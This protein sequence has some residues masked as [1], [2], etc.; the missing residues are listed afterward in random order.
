MTL[1]CHIYLGDEELVEEWRQE[2][3]SPNCAEDGWQCFAAVSEYD[4]LFVCVDDS[5]EHYGHIRHIV[6]NCFEDEVCMVG[7]FDK[8]FGVIEKFAH[9]WVE[10]CQNAQNCGTDLDEVECNFLEYCSQ[11]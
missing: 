10:K 9:H 4:Y 5:S 7:T 3:D 8:L 11:M 6:N 1:R 2:H